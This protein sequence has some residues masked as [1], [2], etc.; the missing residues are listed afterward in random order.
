VAACR[1]AIREAEEELEGLLPALRKAV[2]N[3]SLDYF[4]VSGTSYLIEVRSGSENSKQYCNL[5]YC[6]VQYMTV[7]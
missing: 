6:T 4:S 5:L 1:A 2:R 3:A 7:L